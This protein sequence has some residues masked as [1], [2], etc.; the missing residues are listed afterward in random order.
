[1][2]YP[3]ELFDQCVQHPRRPDPLHHVLR[4]RGG[5]SAIQEIAFSNNILKIRAS[6]VRLNA[7]N[8]YL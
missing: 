4:G 1:V 7:N 8:I 5:L 3:K 2:L 6:L